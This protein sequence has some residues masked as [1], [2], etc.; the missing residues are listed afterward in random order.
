MGDK[1]ESSSG[2]DWQPWEAERQCADNTG[3]TLR[4]KRGEAAITE[5]LFHR[6]FDISAPANFIKPIK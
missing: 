5:L 6:G 4:G 2:R 3:P 1:M